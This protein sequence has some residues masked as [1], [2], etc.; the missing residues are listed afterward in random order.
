MRPTIPVFLFLILILLAGLLPA[1]A[2]ADFIKCIKT[3]LTR[4]DCKSPYRV[5][6]S[7]A[8]GQVQWNANLGGVGIV[9]KD[10][11]GRIRKIFSLGESDVQNLHL[12]SVHVDGALREKLESMG[13]LPRRHH[14]EVANFWL[15]DRL[16]MFNDTDMEDLKGTIAEVNRRMR[17][18][19]RCF[20]TKEPFAADIGPDGYS[21]TVCIGRVQCS[22]RNGGSEYVTTVICLAP[23]FQGDVGSCPN[24]TSC[25]A[26][27]VPEIRTFMPVL[28]RSR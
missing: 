13:A 1:S 11:R 22:P 27:D 16:P 4:C 8:E 12:H 6:C 28:R 15:S 25:L 9:I 5:R 17:P 20:Y 2:E 19:D 18:P 23:G 26:E 10:D 14:Y 7:N 21:T 3:G 24:A